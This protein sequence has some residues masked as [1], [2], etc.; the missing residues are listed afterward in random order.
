MWK[1]GYITVNTISMV[2]LRE[3]PISQRKMKSSI[4]FKPYFISIMRTTIFLGFGLSSSLPFP[5][6]F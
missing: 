2:H 3:V 6:P 4:W 1:G 5:L